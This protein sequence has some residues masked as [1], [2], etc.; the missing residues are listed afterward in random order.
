ML[1]I[2]AVLSDR[3][4]GTGAGRRGGG[5]ARRTIAP[6]VD[7]DVIAVVQLDLARGNLGALAA[8]LAG[9]RPTGIV[10]ER[11]KVLPGWSERLRRAGAR[12]LY[13]VIS[14]D[15]LPGP[16]VVVVPLGPGADAAEIGRLLCGRGGGP[17][18]FAFHA[19]ATI[20]D[21]V[22]AGTPT[23][24]ERIR[25]LKPAERPDL[26]AAFA[27]VG[28]E[29][30][31]VRIVLAPSPDTRRVFEE[32]VPTLPRELG[33]GPITELTRGVVW[34][35]AGL[36]GPRPSFG[37]VIAAPSAEA[38]RALQRRGPALAAFLEKSPFGRDV[39]R[40]VSQLNVDV[41]ADRVR[42]TADA[43]VAASLMDAVLQPV[44]DAAA[45]AQCTNNEKQ[46]ALAMHNYI[47][48]TRPKAMF[49]PAYTTSKDGKPLLSWRVLILPYLEQEALY[50]QFHLD[51]PWDSPHNRTLIARMPE[52]YRCPMESPDAAREGKTRYLAPRGAGTVFR[53][54]EPVSLKDIKDGTSNTIILVD[55]GDDLAVTWTRP[56]DWDV[57]ADDAALKAVFHGHQG[58]VPPG[59]LTAFADGAV[60]FLKES[61]QAGI[62]PSTGHLQRRRDHL[63]GGPLMVAP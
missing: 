1:K 7:S 21:A 49:P 27:A 28:D 61:D 58:R 43:E 12:D 51:E 60:R 57:P 32:L 2:L 16:P 15:D 22:V 62:D 5:S 23:A 26:A 4:R 59:T 40:L 13:V 63:A 14:L 37:L 3:Y 41:A 48:S 47:S 17:A 44:R 45:Q 55:A 53:G 42:L 52:V 25:N 39:P 29:A 19:C 36:D 18:P 34:V 9:D 50:K 11:T 30:M 20:R 35:A 24:L 56:D 10:A 6:F 33:G 38:A 46:I 31:G 8:R 54:A